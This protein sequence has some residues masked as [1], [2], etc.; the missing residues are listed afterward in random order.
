MNALSELE[1]IFPSIDLSLFVI[2]FPNIDLS[3]FAKT[4]NNF[5]N[6]THQ[7]NGTIVLNVHCSGF[8]RDKG[9]KGNINAFL[10]LSS[11]MKLLENFH[12]ALFHNLPTLH[13]WKL[14]KESVRALSLVIIQISHHL[15]HFTLLKMSFQAISLIRINGKE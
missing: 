11:T 10:K 9:H 3:L 15:L 2:I 13:F 14:V 12:N 1:I 5:I 8:L 7:T 6:T 4:K